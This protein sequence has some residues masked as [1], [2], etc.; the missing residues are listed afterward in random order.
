MKFTQPNDNTAVIEVNTEELGGLVATLI[1]A[2][3]AATISRAKGTEFVGETYDK[4]NAEFTRITGDSFET[5]FGT[6][7]LEGIAER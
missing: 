4:F 6:A 7:I 1:F 2:K 3:F 5:I